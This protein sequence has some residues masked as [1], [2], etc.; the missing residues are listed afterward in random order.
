ME[1]SMQ[2]VQII[3]DGDG[4]LR[5]VPRDRVFHTTRGIRLVRMTRGTSFGRATVMIAAPLANGDWSVVEVTERMFLAAA[6][7]F[8]SRSIAEG[9]DTDLMA[10]PAPGDIQVTIDEESPARLER[11]RSW[12]ESTIDQINAKLGQSKSGT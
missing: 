10:D 11:L 12:C 2:T 4:A 6:T 9:V 1:T 3:L 5:D 7:A 8:K